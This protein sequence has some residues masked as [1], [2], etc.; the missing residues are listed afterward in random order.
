MRSLFRSLAVAPLALLMATS[1]APAE[2]RHGLSI[3][4]DLKYAPDFQ[5]F[6]YVNPDAPKGGTLKLIG[7]GADTS[8]D[9]FNGYIVRGTAAQGL[10]LVYDSLMTRALDEPDAVYGLIA[11]WA[12]VAADKKSVTFKLRP[13]AKFADGTR[14]TAEDAAWTFENSQDEG[15]A[16]LRRDPT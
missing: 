7:T 4:G 11:E 10:G 8:Y 16:R 14:V 5:H 9:S 2:P 15:R 1:A 6:E 3:F 12:D 13:E